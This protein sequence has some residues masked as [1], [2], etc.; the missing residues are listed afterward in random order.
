VAMSKSSGSMLYMNNLIKYLG[1]TLGIET[2]VAPL[3]NQL[4]QRLPLYITSAFE[5]LETTIYGQR[6]C[7]LVAE[8]DENIPPPDRLSK[9]ML[10]VS[11]KIELPVVYVFDKV[12]SYNIKRMIQKSVNF[13]IPNKQLFIPALMMNLSRT[14]GKLPQKAVSLT[15][16][17]QF[18]LLYHLQK[19]LLNGF[20]TQLLTE[21]FEQSYRTV[22]RAVKNLE[23]LELCNLY[24]GKE[25]QLQFAAK[26]KELWLR[27]QTV[28]QNPVERILF[29]DK[30][31]NT[32]YTCFSNINA[33][34][35]FTMLNDEAKRY[36]AISKSEIKH[37]AE[38]NKYTGD[39]T[40][41]VWRYNPVPLSD[42]GFIDKLSLYLLFKNDADERI[43]SELEILINKMQWLEE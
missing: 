18:I 21:K 13:I 26:G 4:V 28:L 32:K 24:G 1:E 19:K 42:N 10:F 11:Q 20:T 23:E 40:V 27:A 36:Y 5:A 39:N 16:L 3:E 35:C 12:I 29:T 14:P 8:N 25:K 41:E 33:L 17:A 30:T 38:T 37:L 34:S 2:T 9:Q 7:L 43:Q 15:P 6:I 22:S 31:L